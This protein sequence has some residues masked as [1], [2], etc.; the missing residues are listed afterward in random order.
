MVDTPEPEQIQTPAQYPNA[1]RV[2]NGVAYDISGKPLGPVDPQAQP[3]SSGFDFG[4]GKPQ[5]VAAAPASAPTPQAGYDFGFDNQPQ[6]QPGAV[7][8]FGSGVAAGTKAMLPS[9]ATETAKSVAANLV[10]GGVYSAYEGAKGVYE[11]YTRARDEGQPVI[12][13]VAS[14]IG[15]V[16]GLDPEGIRERAAKGDI[17]G[18]VGE[19]VPAIAAT[20]IGGEHERIAKTFRSDIRAHQVASATHDSA[21]AMFDQRLREQ[22]IAT[23]QAVKAREEA[24]RITQAHDSGDPNVT[25]QHVDDA[26]NRASAAA[27][28]SRKASTALQDA[29]TARIEAGA[30][31]DRL[32][33]KV[34]NI[35]KTSEKQD[36]AVRQAVDNFKKMAPPTNTTQGA[37]SDKDAQIFLGA[38]EKLHETN[39]IHTVEDHVNAAQ[40]LSDDIDTEVGRH[41]DKYGKDA[42]TTNVNQDVRDKLA[43]SPQ[44]D[45]V[46]DGMNH[47]SQKFNLTDPTVEEAQKILTDINALN[48]A[49]L[50]RNFWDVATAL[51]ADPEFAARY[52]AADSLRTGIDGALQERGV[53]GVRGLRRDQASIIRVKTALEKVASKG[54]QPVRG[55][56]ESGWFVKNLAKGASTLG[57][58]GGAGI[59]GTIGYNVGGVVGAEVGGTLGYGMGKAFG[60]R[61]GKRIAPGDLTRDQ[62]ADR[63][64]TVKDKGV[65]LTNLGYEGKAAGQYGP[66]E[67]VSPV[68]QM[69]VPQRENTPL[70]VAIASHYGEILGKSSYVDLE[71]RFLDDVA[72][73]QSHGLPLEP[74]EKKI[75]TEINKANAADTIAA[76]KQ[77]QQNIE[78]GKQL[79]TA[80]LPEKVE[81]LLQAP[82]S[83]LA[84]GMD[85]QMGIVHDIAHAVVADARGL[86][87]SDGIRSHIHPENVSLGSLMSTPIDWTDFVGEDKQIDWNKIKSRMAD[88]AATYVA[89]GVANDLYHDIP[90]GENHHLG[91]DMKALKGIFKDAG[92]TEVE[93][94]KMIRQAQEDAATVLSKPGVQKVIEDHASFREAGLDNQH[95]VSPGRLQQIIQDTKGAS[96]EQPTGKPPANGPGAKGPATGN[97]AGSETATEEGNPAKLR[98]KGKGPAKGKGEGVRRNESAATE[99]QPRPANPKLGTKI[100][101]GSDVV[102]HL[103]KTSKISEE[104]ARYLTK[105]YGAGKYAL[106]D[107]PIQRVPDTQEDLDNFVPRKGYVY[108]GDNYNPALAEKYAKLKSPLP[109]IVLDRDGEVVDG[110]HRIA[111]AD[112]RGDK[113]IKAYVPIENLKPENPKLGAEESEDLMHEL[114]SARKQNWPIEVIDSQGNSRI[115]KVPAFSSKDAI[116]VAQK[117]FPGEST[118]GTTTGPEP[119]PAGEYKVPTGKSH[120]FGNPGVNQEFTKPDINVERHELG[121]ALVGLASGLDVRGMLSHLHPD[122][123]AIGAKRGAVRFEYDNISDP[124]GAIKPES[125]PSLVRSLMGGIAADEVFNEQPR[126][127]NVNFDSTRPG[128]DAGMARRMMLRAGYTEGEIQ[129][130]LHQAV[131]SAKSHLTKP[132]VSDIIKENAG[133]RE[134]GL[135]R[136]FHYSEDRLRAMHNEIQRRAQNGANNT[137]NGGE[138]GS[139]HPENVPG[140]EGG[141]PEAPGRAVETPENPK[142]GLR[143]T[144]TGDP[145]ADE[146]IRDAG[147]IPAGRMFPGEPY[148]LKSFHDPKTGSTLNIKATEPITA[149][150]I[151]QRL[152]DSRAKFAAGI[153]ALKTPENPKLSPNREVPYEVVENYIDRRNQ[154]ADNVMSEYKDSLGKPDQRQK[155]SVVPAGRLK[156]IWNDYAKNGFV[157]DEAGIDRIADTV[158]ENIHKLHANNILTGHSPYSPEEYAEDITGD[159]VPEGHFEKN[160]NFFDDGKG[161]WR[162]TDYGMDKLERGAADLMM[163]K[164]AEDK[165]QAIDY[166]LSVTHMRSDLSSWFVEDGQ[167]TLNSLFGKK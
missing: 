41:V 29:H 133:F 24:E 130:K 62:L 161:G 53:S 150:A 88:I 146:A 132:E 56:G 126:D 65:A 127:N 129:E 111:A 25:Q 136:Q 96:N 92:F 23:D 135:S 163:A 6:A 42:I 19:S 58:A 94:N 142:L 134:P 101:D 60:D 76:Q 167:K 99:P 81:P 43:D 18:I 113:T 141:S 72:D 47:L 155:W 7:S 28:N 125:V 33:R 69:F 79:P 95:H 32:N 50:K 74:D 98:P 121:H 3:Q 77:M 152:A 165:L 17:A 15:G 5:S 156:K 90:A 40:Q 85:T 22:Q 52:W 86:K 140:T 89:G 13:S 137:A 115:E 71:K 38:S 100:V 44:Q 68:M 36:R 144:T 14:G 116:R 153:E 34:Q 107:V 27:A 117:K 112:M 164:T 103:M 4:F 64:H 93:A 154:V 162:I 70:H 104:D 35:P 148:E 55:S 123:Q 120:R 157:R 166:I 75:V 106:K 57:A 151:R 78:S 105:Q 108:A 66:P 158:L 159:K 143:E 45:F 80:T 30:E 73:K 84:K 9:S 26:N 109:A 54:D 49:T 48:R 149:E 128:S 11:G 31:L 82:R 91:A 119:I 139:G 131:D 20:L 102:N 59:G 21:T 87:V 39:P 124:S 67:P 110:N 46:E 51:R 63:I 2:E 83:G 97:G 122:L 10:T 16:A 61:L 1:T 12:S 160:E 145:K 114:Q 147:A 118:W 37:Y 138:G 8:R